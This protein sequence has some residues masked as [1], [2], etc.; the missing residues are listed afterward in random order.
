LLAGIGFVGSFHMGTSPVHRALA[1]LVERLDA[2]HIPYALVGA[3]ALNE[4]GY[5]RATVDIDVLLTA[6]GLARF[7]REWLGRGYVERVPGG[8]G[9]RDVED[10]VAID[11][12]LT[13]EF[14]GDGRP[15]DVV[16]PDPA[17]AAVRGERLAVLPL[18]RLIELKLASGLSAPHRLRDLADVLELIRLR[19]LDESLAERL[20]P[21]VRPKYLELCRAARSAPPD[22][23]R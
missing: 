19:D 17:V 22:A 7:R 10:R 13:G 8:R 12:L 11:V 20:A 6:E 4:H 9:L 15:K 16:F 5:R 18:E 21:S 2:S 3:M 23:D 1:R 14:P